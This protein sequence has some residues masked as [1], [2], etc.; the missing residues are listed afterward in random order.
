M[1]K[2]RILLIIGLF[3]L[4]IISNAQ[5]PRY[6]KT[7]TY[8]G[9]VFPKYCWPNQEI[10]KHPYIPT[11]QEIANMEKKISYSIRILL[12]SLIEKENYKAKCELADDIQMY[13][14]QYYGYWDGKEKIVLIYFYKY[15]PKHW[16]NQIIPISQNGQCDEARIE[17]SIKNDKLFNFF[18]DL[19]KE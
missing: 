15:P 4:P 5:K 9:V 2:S 1:K 16:K 6:I 10:A 19:S 8:E 17:Y 7:D 11:N 13:K 3:L 18:V 12:L 14:R